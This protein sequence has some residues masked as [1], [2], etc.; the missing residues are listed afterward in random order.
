MPG[1][2]LWAAAICA[3]S[4]LPP[5]PNIPITIVSTKVS[6]PQS[7][8]CVKPTKASPSTL[9]IKSWN[10]FTDEIITSM[11]RFDFSSMT[12]LMIWLP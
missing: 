6:T 2:E 4:M 10:G 1:I 12:P 8:S 5:P 11:I 9:P 3:A 7:R